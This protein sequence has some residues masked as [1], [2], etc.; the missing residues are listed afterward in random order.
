[1]GTFV[2]L[3]S[4][5]GGLDA[6]FIQAG[7][8][9]LLAADI[10][11]TALAVHQQNLACTTMKIDLGNSSVPEGPMKECDV[12]LAG[13]PCQGFSTAGKRI[14]DDPR[15]SLLYVTAKVAAQFRPKVVVAENVPAVRSGA[16]KKYWDGLHSRLRR[17]GYS[18]QDLLVNGSDHGLPQLR[19]R[20]FLIAWCT[21]KLVD[22]A[23][24]KRS[25]VSLGSAIVGAELLPNH[26]PVVLLEGSSEL[27]IAKRIQQGQKLTNARA[28]TAAIHTW[29]I[30]EVFGTT[31]ASER[32]VLDSVLRWR[33]QYRRRSFGDADPVSSYFLR[34]HFGN[35]VLEGL[36]EKGYLRKI[37]H[38]HDLADT[39]NGKFRRAMESEPS[40]TVDTRFG[41]PRLFLHPSEHRGFSVRE[42]A[43]IQGF[44]DEFLFSGSRAAQ[45]RMVGNAVPPPIAKQLGE[46]VR[47]LL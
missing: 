28:G 6:G 39:Y 44:D 31:T 4:G 13:S 22:V 10:D 38:Y 15:N 2:S 30:P 7:Y 18:T 46:V 3:F 16:H 12:L 24:E 11:A 42:A 36:V 25:P 9:G 40:Y 29:H 47:Q 34:K 8:R 45:F 20:L 27:A 35:A 1:M 33:R 17:A 23:L 26:E 21:G 5:C 19:K 32:E 41:D 43:R 37:G 14:V